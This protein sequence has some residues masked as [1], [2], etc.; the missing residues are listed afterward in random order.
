MGCGCKNKNKKSK[1]QQQV[2]RVKTTSQ[3]GSTP[4]GMPIKEYLKAVNSQKKR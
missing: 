1:L 3:S 4:G 2:Q